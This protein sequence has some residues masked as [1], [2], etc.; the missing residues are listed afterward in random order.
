MVS[1]EALQTIVQL[2]GETELYNYYQG[3]Y[4]VSSIEWTP[5]KARQIL[6]VIPQAIIC[7]M[8]YI[9]PFTL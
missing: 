9:S 2:M 4:Y 1:A 5:D 8:L 6:E 3:N 7:T